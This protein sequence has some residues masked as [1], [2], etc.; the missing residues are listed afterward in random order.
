MTP[1]EKLQYW[2]DAHSI[3]P[4]TFAMQHQIDPSHLSKILREEVTKIG[5]KMAVAIE[6][7]TEGYVRCEDWV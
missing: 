3:T 2:L 6:T 4:H 7:A 1:A 5:V